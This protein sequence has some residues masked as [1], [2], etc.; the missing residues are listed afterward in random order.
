MNDRTKE[1]SRETL[2]SAMP[3]A[4][5]FYAIRAPN[6]EEDPLF[7]LIRK[8]VQEFFLVKRPDGSEYW[9][10]DVPISGADF[11]AR[12]LEL[13]AAEGLL[14][15]GR[16]R[17]A[18][19]SG[20]K[21]GDRVA[22]PRSELAE[23]ESGLPLDHHYPWPDGDWI[24]VDPKERVVRHAGILEEYGTC[25]LDIGSVSVHTMCYHF[26]DQVFVPVCSDEP[27]GS[28]SCLPAS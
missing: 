16:Y 24:V 28:D 13:L 11:L 26:G 1:V 7:V 20:L 15:H 22:I 5:E 12:A 21:R 25:R 14:P 6:A 19:W 18:S 2:I 3:P 23:V 17:K 9:D 4:W 10:A 27:G 8:L